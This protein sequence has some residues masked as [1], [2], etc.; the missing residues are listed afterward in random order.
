[1]AGLMGGAGLLLL[2]SAVPEGIFMALMFYCESHLEM[3][4][5]IIGGGAMTISM[6][7]IGIVL[8]R[9]CIYI[10]RRSRGTADRAI[11]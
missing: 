9:L 1:M 3:R 5:A 11:R 8:Y 7:V 10:T 6:A 2:M 4:V